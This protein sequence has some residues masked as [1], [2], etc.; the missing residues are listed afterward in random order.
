MRQEAAVEAIAKSNPKDAC[1]SDLRHNGK[2]LNEKD[3]K[4]RSVAELHHAEGKPLC[5]SAGKQAGAEE[6]DDEFAPHSLER[7]Q[8]AEVRKFSCGKHH[9]VQRHAVDHHPRGNKGKEK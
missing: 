5:D 3:N 9:I 1:K 7:K 4:N 6:D 2:N 8:K